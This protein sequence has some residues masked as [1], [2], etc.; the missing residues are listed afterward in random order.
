MPEKD[1]VRST[2]MFSTTPVQLFFS[3]DTEDNNKR[4][5]QDK[6][7]PDRVTRIRGKELGSRVL[8][9]QQHVHES[10]VHRHTIMKVTN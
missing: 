8:G 1:V 10:A 4:R 9:M 6:C 3:E 5:S 2:C 7:L